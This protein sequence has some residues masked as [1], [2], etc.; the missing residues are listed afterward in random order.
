MRKK[1]FLYIVVI[2]IPLALGLVAWQSVRYRLLEREVEKLS[3]F[4]EELI[5]KNKNLL[6]DIAELSSPARL[7]RI[8]K[9]DFGLEQKDPEDVLQVIIDPGKK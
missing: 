6:S 4:Q 2:S 9:D 1:V 7:E 3:G 5:V 8:A